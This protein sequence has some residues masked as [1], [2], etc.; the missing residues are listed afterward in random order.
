MGKQTALWRIVL[1]SFLIIIGPCAL[2]AT[3]CP[4][5]GATD[6]PSLSMACPE[7]GANIYDYKYDK[8]GTDRSALIVR[9]YYTGDNPDK[10]SSY[11][12]LFVNGKYMGNIEQIEKQSRKTEGMHG[13]SDGL[14]NEFTALY[15]KEFRNIPVGMLKVEIEMRFNRLYGYGRSYKRVAFPYVQFNGK[16]KTF[17][18]HHFESAVDFTVPDKEKKNKKPDINVKDIPIVSDT[19]VIAGSGTVKLDVGVFE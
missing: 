17:I 16:Q 8:K 13:W 1:I 9:L 2:W 3:D 11:A 19:K 15:E 12:K 14:G 5:C 18:E 10:L 6:V 4:S 7:C